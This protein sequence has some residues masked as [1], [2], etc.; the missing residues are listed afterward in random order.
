MSNPNMKTVLHTIVNDDGVVNVTIGHMAYYQLARTSVALIK[1]MAPE[2]YAAYKAAKYPKGE[3]TDESRRDAY[4]LAIAEA[5]SL[6]L[7]E[8]AITD[9]TPKA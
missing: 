4:K 7:Y 2:A 3:A 5:A 6:P 9:E 1:E 8:R